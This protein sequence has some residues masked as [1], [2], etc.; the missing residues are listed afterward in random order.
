MIGRLGIV[1][2]LIALCPDSRSATYYVEKDGDDSD[3]GTSVELAWLTGQ[4]AVA[5]AVA[6]D[7]VQFGIGEWNEY[8][9]NANSGTAGSRI[10]FAGTRDSGGWKTV[11]NPSTIF[12]NGWVAASEIGSGIYKLTNMPF[13]VRELTINNQRVAFVYSNGPMS[14]I[15]SAYSGSGYTAGT[16]FLKHPSA[17]T[18]TM[19]VNGSQVCTWW[20]SVSALWSYQSN[21]THTVY[22]RLRDGSDP[23]GLLIRAARNTDNFTTDL[24]YPAI[25]IVDKSFITWS[26]F[27]IRG[28]AAGVYISGSSANNVAI[29]SNSIANGWARITIA[30]RAYFN[31]IRGNT[32]TPDYYG[33]TNPG[34]WSGGTAS[35]YSERANI[36]QVSKHLMSVQDESFDESISLFGAGPTNTIVWNTISSGIGVGISISGNIGSY[37]V[38]TNTII[39]SNSIAKVPSAGILFSVGNTQT[40]AFGNYLSDCN[41]SWRPHQMDNTSE[42]IVYNF[43]SRSWLPD[44][45]GTH[46][47]LHFNNGT[48]GYVSQWWHYHLS[49]S[50]GYGGV[51]ASSFAYDEGGLT[52]SFWVDD[53]F[54]DVPYW[55]STDSSWTNTPVGAF[56]YNLI[57]V[58][59]PS[60]PST[61]APTFF[62]A[63]NIVQALPEWLNAEGMPM[64]LTSGSRALDYGLDLTQTFDIGGVSYDPLPTDSTVKY[65]VG[66]D[67]GALEFQG[68]QGTRGKPIKLRK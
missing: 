39:C 38:T 66:W 42:R 8:L 52:N 9:T 20:D 48:P 33:H 58:P 26:N 61:N 65:S 6:G 53:I 64:L 24:H 35:L 46:F 68:I 63:S 32:L 41:I 16:N 45:A 13:A 15:A 51:E 60:Y 4:K 36:Y 10:T 2:L 29:E 55:T 49:M 19:T 11:I 7:F 5:T 34:A 23:N 22:L 3:P 56:D 59:F 12:S 28:S 18:L 25:R 27:L 21:D 30:N 1:V 62:G 31:T 47:Y 57:N 54:S 17:G 43:R 67:L 37:P 44:G 14:S 50:G 40:R